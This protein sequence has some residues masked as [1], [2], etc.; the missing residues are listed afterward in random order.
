MTTDPHHPPRTALVRWLS[1][2]VMAALVAWAAQP[3]LSI[4]LVAIEGVAP[5][6]GR[7]FMPILSG[8]LLA[9]MLAALRYQLRLTSLWAQIARACIWCGALLLSTL[10][11]LIL[12]LM[13]EMPMDGRQDQGSGAAAGFM[14]LIFGG[15][16]G[17]IGGLLLVLGLLLRRQADG[18]RQGA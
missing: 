5:L 3:A 2:L 6:D 7:F 1:A 15:Y 8:L 11:L 14:L 12:I 17:I 9:V 13:A 16:H 10:P 4:L 18:A